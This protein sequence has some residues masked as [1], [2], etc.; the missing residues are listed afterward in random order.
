MGC[1]RK[2]PNLLVNLVQNNLKKVNETN[3][4]SVIFDKN[5]RFDNYIYNI[6]Q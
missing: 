4:L 2:D 6:C 5:L 3:I 1:S